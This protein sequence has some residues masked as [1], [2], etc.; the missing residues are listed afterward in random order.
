MDIK[1]FK[2]ERSK[3]SHSDK[4]KENGSNM[5]EMNTKHHETQMHLVHSRHKAKALKNKMN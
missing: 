4:I 2:K 1:K 5:R 3:M